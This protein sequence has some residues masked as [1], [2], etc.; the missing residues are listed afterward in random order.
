VNLLTGDGVLARLEA[1]PDRY[2]DRLWIRMVREDG[3][4]LAGLIDRLEW[5][6]EPC[7]RTVLGVGDGQLFL[8]QTLPTLPQQT[9]RAHALRMT[10]R[11]AGHLD[12]GA[13][14]VVNA[15]RI[16]NGA[17][18]KRVE[19][20]PNA[21]GEEIVP[22]LPNV[23]WTDQVRLCVQ[24]EQGPD[25]EIGPGAGEVPEPT[26][27][28]MD[29]ALA[30]TRAH[31]TAFWARSGVCLADQL[32]ERAWYRS[33]YLHGCSAKTDGV[34]PGLYGP[35]VADTFGRA[36][37][38]DYHMNYNAQQ[39]LWGLFSCNHPDLHLPYV[40]LVRDWLPCH[41]RYARTFYDLPGAAY[42]LSLY[43]V[44]TATP[45]IPSPPWNM[46]LSIPPWTVQ[47]LWW[48][49]LYTADETFLREQAFEPIKQVAAFLNAYMRRPEAHGP[50]SPWKDGKFHIYPSF[51]PEMRHMFGF[52][53]DPKYNDCIVDLTL[54]RFAFNAYLQSCGILEREALESALLA[55]VRE[56]LVHFPEYVV[57][58]HP[59]GGKVYR[60]VKGSDPETI[61]NTPNPMMHIFPGEEIGLHSPPESLEIARRTWRLHRN[62]GG[63][64][65]VFQAVQGARLGILDLEK[66]KRQ[67]HYC[68]LPNGSFTDMILQVGGR[69]PEGFPFAWMESMGIWSENFAVPFVINECLLQ[70]YHGELRFFPN[71][72]VK[73]G[74]ARFENLRAVGAVLVSASLTD[75]VVGTVRIVSEKGHDCT[76]VNPWP[77]KCVRL[78]RNGVKAE[79]VGSARFVFKTSFGEAVDLVCE[80]A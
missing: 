16:K 55:E 72:P 59:E 80:Q 33:L 23:R 74:A 39:V 4:P 67:L 73:Q 44:V 48:H 36:W 21:L 37:H 51:V 66:W 22:V 40:R 76:V 70:S 12:A 27:A 30:A 17:T 64:D 26:L 20:D 35:W 2:A 31:W 29:E 53:S 65:L 18:G 56:V 68:E 71:W 42:T 52:S 13:L 46:Q 50:D 25:R 63:N 47:S 3:K 9:D 8:R 1:I 69:Y 7:E 49:Y 5:S 19:E 10:V 62:E 41:Q 38:S 77:G 11:V 60:D 61:Y 54:A 6:P 58:E 45:P 75:G 28:A 32:L 14:K 57:A 78:I 24:L 15:A 34:Q 43:P 79:L